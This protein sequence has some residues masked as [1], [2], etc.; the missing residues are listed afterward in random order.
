ML[1]G[2]QPANLQNCLMD[3]QSNVV[4]TDTLIEFTVAPASGFIIYP[5]YVLEIDF[6]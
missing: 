2:T 6:P 3:F 5:D 4:Y 1:T